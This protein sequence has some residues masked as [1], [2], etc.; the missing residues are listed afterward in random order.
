ME[1]VSDRE[2]KRDSAKKHRDHSVYTQKAIRIREAQLEK[3]K[4]C[5]AQGSSK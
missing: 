3:K 2:K 1:K 5:S 4:S